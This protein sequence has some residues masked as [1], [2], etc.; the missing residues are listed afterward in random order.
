MEPPS[1]TARFL[2]RLVLISN[3]A[4]SPA[5]AARTVRT[6]H[7]FILLKWSCLLRFANTTGNVSSLVFF[8][9]LVVRSTT[10]KDGPGSPQT[11]ASPFLSSFLIKFYSGVSL[12]TPRPAR[13]TPSLSHFL[14]SASEIYFSLFIHSPCL[15]DIWHSSVTQLNSL[16]QLQTTG[17]VVFPLKIIFLSKNVFLSFLAHLN[18]AI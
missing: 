2:G 11:T 13:S 7:S 15:T 3:E 16:G 18:P 4:A 17:M 14:G 1:S 8:F 5:T 9:G 10:V 6:L 12:F